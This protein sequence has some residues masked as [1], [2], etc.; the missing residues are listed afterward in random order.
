MKKI[1]LGLTIIFFS[2]NEKK[3]TEFSLNGT[4]SGIQNGTT[5]YL[6]YKNELIDSTKVENNTF[7]FNSKLPKSPI[8][9]LL[10][11]KDL[12]N[13]RFLWV[14]NNPMTFDA[15]KTDFRNAKITGSES[16][17]LS[18]S[19]H[20]KI[21]TLPRNE[22]Q[23]MEMEFVKTN[24][25]SIVSASMLSFY[26]KTWGK[27]K[28]KELYEQ[29]SIENKNTLFGKEITKYIEL[30]KNPK[31]GEQF[32]DFESENQNGELKKLSDLKGKVVLL[33]FW[34][35]WC[36]PCRQENPNL[37]KTYEKFNP[38]GFEIFAVSL[39]QDKEN[40]LKAIKKDSLSWEHVSD[41]KGQGN[42][43]SLIYGVNE[44]PDNFLISESG[45]IIGR[46]LRREKLN[47]K[48]K[49]LLE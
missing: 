33:E 16:E 1:I 6:D 43:A 15:T 24:P 4:T 40:W 22:R 10:R 41:L 19:L 31:I 42:E 13:Y 23:K 32:V 37:V 5:L 11:T 44:M 28:T 48:L 9:V 27:E 26:S 20:Q 8:Q 12:S 14:E 38:K 36:G 49:K 3:N 25:N 39:D 46:N 7:K 30:N 47:Q 17:N 2:C 34:A 29:L 35:S 45:E 21:D 18:F